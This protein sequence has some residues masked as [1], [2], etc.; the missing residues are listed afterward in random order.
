MRAENRSGTGGCTPASVR[1]GGEA[2]CGALAGRARSAVQRVSEEAIQRA[3][4]DLLGRAARP[5]VVF[6]HMPSGEARHKAV[7]GK[8]KGLGVK[9]GWPDLLIVA[10]GQLYGLELKTIAGRVSHAQKAAH[11]EL[12]AAGA[13]VAVAY[14]IDEAMRQ[15]KAWGLVRA[16]DS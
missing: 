2:A 5:G 7:A 8:L 12:T 3:V 4:V 15:L 1:G 6:T 10:G 16:G 9:P 14:G 11:A 13:I